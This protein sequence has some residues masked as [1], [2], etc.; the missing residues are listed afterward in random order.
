MKFKHDPDGPSLVYA[1]A[2]TQ[3]DGIGQ[4]LNVFAMLWLMR[5]N[6][7]VDAYIGK[8]TYMELARVFDEST[9]D[10]PVLDDHFCDP[11]KI[12]FEYYSGPFN[13]SI[14]LI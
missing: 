6:F 14:V 3:A 11:D 2:L 12:S 13:V 9:L 5:R 10:I 7:N 8:R 1:E 4:N